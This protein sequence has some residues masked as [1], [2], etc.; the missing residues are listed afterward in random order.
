MWS[1]SGVI[2][3]CNSKSSSPTRGIKDAIHQVVHSVCCGEPSSGRGCACSRCSHGRRSPLER[4]ELA[5]NLGRRTPA[6]S[7]TSLDFRDRDGHGSVSWERRRELPTC[8]A[9]E[10][11]TRSRTRL[12]R[13]DRDRHGGVPRA[14][15]VGFA[16]ARSSRIGRTF[17]P[18]FVLNQ[19]VIDHCATRDYPFGCSL[20]QSKEGDRCGSRTE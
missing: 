12:D 18:G 8:R 17:P 6:I 7:G 5:T 3:C 2:L 11:S 14:L 10:C 13:D 16:G 19:C 1:R 15:S 9:G 4:R 20:G